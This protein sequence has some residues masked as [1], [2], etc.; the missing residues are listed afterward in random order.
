MVSIAFVWNCMW[1][2]LILY[3]YALLRCIRFTLNVTKQCVHTKSEILYCIHAFSFG[4]IYFHFVGPFFIVHMLNDS[5]RCPQRMKQK[6][7]VNRF[8]VKLYLSFSNIGFGVKRLPWENFLDLSLVSGVSWFF[9]WRISKKEKKKPLHLAFL[10][11][12]FN[13]RMPTV[14]YFIF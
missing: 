14:Q 3:I 5:F 8:S 6:I 2:L 1:L 13:E 9:F 4:F 12:I 11:N 7:G 10:D